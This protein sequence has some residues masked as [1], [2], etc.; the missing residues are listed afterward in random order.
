[1]LSMSVGI[2]KT[3][4]N[5][6]VLKKVAIIQSNYIPWKGYFDII[7][8]VDEFVLYDDVQYTRRDWRNRN[9]IKTASGVRWLTIPVAVSGKYFQLIKDTEVFE[10]GWGQN[11]FEVL[12]QSYAS[13]KFWYQ[14]VDWLK[15]LYE[16][17][18]KYTHLSDINRL[19]IDAICKQLQI[20]TRITFSSK[21]E[22]V[23]GRSE[24]L[25]SVCKALDADVYVSGPA[26]INYLDEKV[27]NEQG[28]KVE[29]F[30]YGNYTPYEQVHPPFEHGVSIL[31]L[32][33]NL[34]PD[35]M[36]YMNSYKI[37]NSIN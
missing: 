25:L 9:K 1:M 14:H 20:S 10:K 31:D 19:F 21:Y 15:S 6:A 17:A 32:I 35:A 2:F 33:L 3:S 11:H 23:P 30:E 36:H 18:E 26:A 27:F 12:R 13:A 4:F 28:M 16:E 5:E 22:L 24:K 7:N 8:S 29:W 37:K 34:G